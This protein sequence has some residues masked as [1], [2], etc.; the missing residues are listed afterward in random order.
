M[1]SKEYIL[2]YRFLH[3]KEI[4]ENR[5]PQQYEDYASKF[6]LENSMILTEE[7]ER[8]VIQTHEV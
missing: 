4:P 3:E 5:N 7:L 1:D 6:K 2:L 8:K